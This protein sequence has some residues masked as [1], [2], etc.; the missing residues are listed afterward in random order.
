M[1]KFRYKWKKSNYWSF[2]LSNDAVAASLHHSQLCKLADIARSEPHL[3]PAS[4]SD[5]E[6]LTHWTRPGMEPT[7]SQTLCWVLNTLSYNG[8]SVMLLLIP[9]LY[10]IFFLILELTS[11]I[12]DVDQLSSSTSKK[13]LHFY[14]INIEQRSHRNSLEN[15]WIENSIPS[16]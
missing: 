9:K 4:C 7:S 13:E 2:L 1:K 10:K 6:S 11:F 16:L 5:T 12:H 14:I 8:N 15:C 3:Q